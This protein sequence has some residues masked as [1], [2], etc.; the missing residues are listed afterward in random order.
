MTSGCLRMAGGA[1]GLELPGLVLAGSPLGATWGGH[2]G[3]T[4]GVQCGDPQHPIAPDR[5]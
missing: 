5:S 1:H 2:W 4:M 3:E